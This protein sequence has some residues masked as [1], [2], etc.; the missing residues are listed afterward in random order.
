MIDMTPLHPWKAFHPIV[1]T[2]VGM[3]IDVSP[4]HPEK[5]S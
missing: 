2:D 1:V 5:V 4:V 3:M